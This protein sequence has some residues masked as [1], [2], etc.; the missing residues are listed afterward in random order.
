MSGTPRLCLIEDDVIMGESLCD[1][2]A[3]EG[4]TFDWHRDGRSAL[5]SIGRESY[6][7]IISDVRLPDVDGEELLRTLLARGVRLP[8]FLFITAYASVAARR[9]GAQAGGHGL[10]HQAVRHRSS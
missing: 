4:F 2:F 3:L 6:A 10:H 1:R 5:R 8:P 9:G 7:A